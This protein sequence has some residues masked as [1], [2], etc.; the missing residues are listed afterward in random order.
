M[1][2]VHPGPPI[3]CV[4]AGVLRWLA[5]QSQIAPVSRQIPRKQRLLQGILELCGFESRL[6]E[7]KLPCCWHFLFDS[8][9][10]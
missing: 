2:D 1:V 4:F 7:E 5:T 10:M 9:T 8:L 3:A 6:H